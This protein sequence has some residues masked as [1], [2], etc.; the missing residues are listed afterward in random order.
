M[1]TTFVGR[2]AELEVIEGLLA[3]LGE[4]RGGA[5]GILGEAGIGKTR[6]L[7]ELVERADMRGYLAL[8]GA[9]SELDRDVPFWVF[10]DALDEYVRGLP[11]RVL[12]GLDGAVLAQLAYVLPAFADMATDA[13]PPMAHERYRSHRAV[14]MLL[15]RLTANTPLVLVLDDSALG[16]LWLVGVAAHAPAA[17]IDYAHVDRLCGSGRISSRIG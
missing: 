13:H 16:R 12:A 2:T 14:R 7:A 11:P 15:E 1:T 4:G 5:L 10:A 3:G 6:L 17:A 8:S 9:A